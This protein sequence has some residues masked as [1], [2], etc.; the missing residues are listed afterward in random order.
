MLKLHQIGRLN[1]KLLNIPDTLIKLDYVANTS[2]TV[3]NV[4]N[5]ASCTLIST[6]NILDYNPI[7]K[8]KSSLF[9]SR[10]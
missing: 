3:E 7:A 10:V 9:S 6:P 2:A 4:H 1:L 5:L 8:L